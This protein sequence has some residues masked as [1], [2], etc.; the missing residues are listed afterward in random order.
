MWE[1]RFTEMCNRVAT[2]MRITLDPNKNYS[3]PEEYN[4]IANNLVK[5]LRPKMSRLSSLHISY[6]QNVFSDMNLV[7]DLLHEKTKATN[8]VIVEDIFAWL[9]YNLYD[10]KLAINDL[11]DDQQAIIKVLACYIIIS[12]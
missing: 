2:G 9:A 8:G 11:T 4:G 7:A 1:E 5:Q 10:G 12:N 6:I 3:L